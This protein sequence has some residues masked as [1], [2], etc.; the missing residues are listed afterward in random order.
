[1]YRRLAL[2]A[3]G[4][5]LAGWL[6]VPQAKADDDSVVKI[7]TNVPLEIPGEVL[8]PGTYELRLMD[9]ATMSD[10][11]AITGIDGRFYGF[12]D[13]IPDYREHATDGVGLKLEKL[14]GA[15]ERIEAWFT[16]GEHEGL[17]FVYPS[18]QVTRLAQHHAKAAGSSGD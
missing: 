16:P 8:A 11:V 6:A 7:T 18:G 2:I 12:H 5:V 14:P 17:E 10:M 13:V 9:P 3:A 4:L 1:M 15:P